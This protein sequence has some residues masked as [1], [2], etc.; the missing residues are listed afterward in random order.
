[1]NP[2][3]QG[4]KE[5]TQDQGIDYQGKPGDYV[6]AIGKARIDAVKSDPGGFG[7]VVYYTLL[8]GPSKGTQVY[9]GHAKPVV[10][11]GQVVAAGRPISML[12]HNSGGGAPPGWAEIGIAQ[13]GVPMYKGTTHAGSTQ[14]GQAL[15]GL[16]SGA[17]NAPTQTGQDAGQQPT[18]DQSQQ[19]QREPDYA[20]QQSIANI[21][22][23][24]GPEVATFK[25]SG[26]QPGYP[27][28]PLSTPADTWQL[29]ASNGQVSPETL[30]LAGL[31]G[32]GS[33]PAQG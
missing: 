12:V 14:G 21:P 13:G 5:V 20:L 2:V 28:Q 22:T 24:P 32:Y 15:L 3:P 4:T 17:G 19:Q 10:H 25:M 7:V 33:G 6:V 31:A 16:L 26:D 30:R 8:D 27:A 1:V 23:L 18:Q 29:I 11:A 9:V